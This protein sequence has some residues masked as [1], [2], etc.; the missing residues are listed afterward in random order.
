MKN[1][2]ISEEF[3]FQS[4]PFRSCHASTIVEVGDG[5]VAG[6]FAGSDEGQP[7]VG[8]WTARW[9][10]GSGWTAPREL[11]NGLQPDGSRD[12]CWNPVLFRYSN[13]CLFLFYKVGPSPAAWWGMV[14]HSSDEGASWSEPVRLPGD[15]IGP[16]KNKPILLENG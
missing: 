9:R 16:V 13:G 3:I 2:S 7:D 12:P 8:I 6:W 1:I 15:V 10:S 14:M 11:T 4:V 5:L